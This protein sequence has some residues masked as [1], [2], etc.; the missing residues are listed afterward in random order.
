MKAIRQLCVA[1][2]IILALTTSAFA[3]E[4][5]TPIAPPPPAQAMGQ[6]DTG[7]SAET[8]TDSLTAVA[9]NLFQSALSLF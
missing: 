5:S 1:S 6:I 8:T 4:I 2:V 9:L 3:G 7:V